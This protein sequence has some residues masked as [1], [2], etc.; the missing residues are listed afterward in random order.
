MDRRVGGTITFILLIVV[1]GFSASKHKPPISSGK[2]PGDCDWT[3]NAVARE[4]VKDRDPSVA[5][6]YHEIGT[7]A[8]PKAPAWW[9]DTVCTNWE[10]KVKNTNVDDNTGVLDL[11]KQKVTL[12]GWIVAVKFE[13]GQD[14]D[15][16]VELSGTPA[17][18]PAGHLIAEVPGGEAFCNPRQTLWSLISGDPNAHGDKFA[19]KNP[20]KVIVTGFVFFDSHHVGKTCEDSGGRGILGPNKEPA[21]VKGVWELHPVI[22]LS[23][24]P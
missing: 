23:K 8:L 17:W 20:V 19:L 16:H 3:Q 14:H 6:G 18:E 9:F 4:P 5:A 24:A 7:P 11:E 1:S 21:N 15:L 12:T 22:A 13:R 2:S 10:P